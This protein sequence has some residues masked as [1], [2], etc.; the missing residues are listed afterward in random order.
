[1]SKALTKSQ[2][3]GAIA[4]KAEISKKQA[5]AILEIIAALAY[6]NAKNSFTLPGLGKLVLVNR[7]ARQGRNPA[8]GETI[9]IKAKKV[10]KFRVAKAAKDAILGAK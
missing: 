2:I 4:E 7:K 5:T 8:T 9:Q 3:A 1:M 10:V 6:K